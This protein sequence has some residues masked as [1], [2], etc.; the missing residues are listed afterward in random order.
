MTQVSIDSNILLYAEGVGDARRQSLARDCLARFKLENLR[1][2]SQVLGEFFSVAY[3]KGDFSRDE[4]REMVMA[5]Q[6][7]VLT[8]STSTN[9]FQAALDLSARH[10]LQIWDA[11]IVATSKEHGCKA[12]LSE[13]MQDGF[14]W[15]GIEVINPFAPDAAAR[16]AQ[17]L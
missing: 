13:D 14:S 7:A 10:K 12:L 1:I 8:L 6:D 16:L 17:H 4:A 11:I 9:A 15:Q 3:R 2:T 5:W